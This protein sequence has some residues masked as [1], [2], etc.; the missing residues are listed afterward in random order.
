MLAVS[1]DVAPLSVV[2]FL[3]SVVVTNLRHQSCQAFVAV[4]FVAHCILSTGKHLVE[5][6]VQ[7]RNEL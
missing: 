4:G 7:D 5:S 3:N 6:L 1:S 2:E